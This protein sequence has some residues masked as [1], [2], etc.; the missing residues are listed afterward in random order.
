M[1]MSLMSARPV[2]ASER[3]PMTFRFASPI[4]IALRTVSRD[5]LD[6]LRHLLGLRRR[7][8]QHVRRRRRRHCA[9]SRPARRAT[10]PIASQSV[11]ED[12][13]LQHVREP[14]ALTRAPMR[15]G[16]RLCSAVGGAPC[17]LRAGMRSQVA[18]GEVRGSRVR[19]EARLTLDPIPSTRA[20]I[21]AQCVAS[22]PQ[23]LSTIRTPNML[24]ELAEHVRPSTP[25]ERDRTSVAL[26]PV[27]TEGP[28]LR[29]CT[30]RDPLEFRAR[31]TESARA[32]APDLWS[33]SANESTWRAATS[34]RAR[35]VRCRGAA[36]DV[37]T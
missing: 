22:I 24:D 4:M 1:L 20:L 23:P 8:E 33:S 3:A 26:L 19:V 28:A 5:Q 21:A 9:R 13:R 7:V 35:D 25:F 10:A 12:R 2:I 34:H 17:T 36:S 16:L 15:S 6:D 31:G 30:T 37:S 18:A 11:G 14:C 32:C 29:K 27:F